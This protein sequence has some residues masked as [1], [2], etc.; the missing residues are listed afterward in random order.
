MI[1]QH[2]Q[3]FSQQFNNSRNMLVS[4]GCD[5]QSLHFHTSKWRRC[6]RTKYFMLIQATEWFLENLLMEIIS[7]SF[8]LRFAE[9]LRNKQVNHSIEAKSSSNH[10]MPA[11]RKMFPHYL[12]AHQVNFK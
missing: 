5:F 11:W 3:W 10:D 9:I 12:V 4:I 2:I 6:F 7:L 8:N 1:E